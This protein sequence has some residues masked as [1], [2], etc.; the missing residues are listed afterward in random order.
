MQR[1][2]KPRVDWSLREACR[3]NAA[4]TLSELLRRR[5]WAAPYHL[6]AGLSLLAEL[7]RAPGT[8]GVTRAGY[9]RTLRGKGR[10]ISLMSA[11]KAAGFDLINGTEVRELAQQIRDET[12]KFT[13]KS[14]RDEGLATL[15]GL[16]LAG[17]VE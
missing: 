10:P 2:V 14:L 16:T 7:C 5:N 1:G 4:A 15:V 17:G 11:A 9:A 6:G 8:Y 13:E 3:Q 12:K